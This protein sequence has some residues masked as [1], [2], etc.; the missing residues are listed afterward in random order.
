MTETAMQ[1]RTQG[2][3][4]HDEPM[5]RHTSWR[6]GGPAD[7]Y[8]RPSHLEELAAFLR[9]LPDDEPVLWVGLGSNLLVR[10]G[11]FRGT[12]IAT[13]AALGRIERES[14]GRVYAEAGVACAKAA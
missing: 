13:H 14:D 1:R 10:D 6:L 2:S 7:C 9:E 5:S 8:F 12:V 4:L 11:G 3:L